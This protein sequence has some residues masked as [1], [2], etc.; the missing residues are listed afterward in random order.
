M[1][2]QKGAYTM[3]ELMDYLTDFNPIPGIFVTILV[4]TALILVLRKVVLWY[5]KIDRMVELLEDIKSALTS[6][7]KTED[8]WACP[9]C[10]VVNP[11]DVY[12]CTGCGYSLT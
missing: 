7:S 10:K 3:F 6:Q 9:K 4:T 11:N 5:Y 1:D 12:K 8:T 2:P